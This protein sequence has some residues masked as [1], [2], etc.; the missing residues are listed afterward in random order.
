V[1]KRIDDI[2]AASAIEALDSDHWFGDIEKEL[3]C[4][5]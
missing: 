3:K 2:H 5:S 4:K 1:R